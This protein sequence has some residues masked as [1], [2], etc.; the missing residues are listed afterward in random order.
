LRILLLTGHPL[1]Q[2]Q[3]SIVAVLENA[4]ARLQAAG[5]RV[6]RESDLLPDLS[7][8]HRH[9]MHMLNIAMTRGAATP[10]REAPTL[11]EW[12]TLGD[13]QARCR[14]A[15]AR[16]FDHYDAV[17]SPT[18]GMTAFP[19]DDTPLAERHLMI[20]GVDTRF[21]AQFAFPGLATFPM[22][23]AT[24]VPIGVDPNGLPIGVQVIADMW[25]D[26]DAIAVARTMHDLVWSK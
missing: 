20:D 4:A 12:F 14:R 9:Y 17:I 3:A 15:W 2:V 26:H 19:H 21:G 6:D 1:A 13:H 5:A 11:A 23:P 10:G 7:E 16:L 24:S 25:R 8:Q 22:L 18:V